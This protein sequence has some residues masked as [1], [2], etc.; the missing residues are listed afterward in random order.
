[1]VLCVTGSLQ[2]SW[3][4]LCL[5]TILS[6]ALK[7]SDPAD[8]WWENATCQ[9]SVLHSVS[10]CL[11]VY[12]T[13]LWGSSKCKLQEQKHTV[14]VLEFFF[15]MFPLILIIG[16]GHDDY[17]LMCGKKDVNFPCCFPICLEHYGISS[18]SSSPPPPTPP[19]S[20]SLFTVVYFW[21][22]S[23][24]LNQRYVDTKYILSML[25]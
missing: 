4:I 7:K 18:S 24:R 11:T 21:H 1:M 16:I 20:P 12:W 14:I 15:E 10:V 3:V 17:L 13:I 6:I 5:P 8:S 9:S 2:Y 22:V 23:M 25:L 19:P